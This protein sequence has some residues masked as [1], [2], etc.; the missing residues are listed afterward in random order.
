M[1]G[2]NKKSE[3]MFFGNEANVQQIVLCLRDVCCI[4]HACR[5]VPLLSPL[6]LGRGRYDV[7]PSSWLWSSWVT[8]WTTGLLTSSHQFPH[9]HLC[10]LLT[11]GWSKGGGQE[12]ECIF[13]SPSQV[14]WFGNTDV[15]C[16]AGATVTGLFGA[17]LGWDSPIF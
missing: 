2:R 6:S 10:E 8:L 1:S 4:N 12:A 11:V 17:Q 15:E 7:F 9:P 5:P 14:N 3:Y 13:V 16:G